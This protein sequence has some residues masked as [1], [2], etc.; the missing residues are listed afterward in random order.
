MQPKHVKAIP[1]AIKLR[2]VWYFKVGNVM[3]GNNL[4]NSIYLFSQTI[5]TMVHDVR[6]INWHVND[7]LSKVQVYT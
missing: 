3:S 1:F 7:I 6:V 2:R 5:S 4:I